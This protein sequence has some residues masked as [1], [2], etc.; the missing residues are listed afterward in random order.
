METG[1]EKRVEST[2]KMWNRTRKKSLGALPAGLL[3]L[4]GT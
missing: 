1:Q 2:I 3:G 4:C